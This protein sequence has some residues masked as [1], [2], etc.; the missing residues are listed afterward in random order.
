VVKSFTANAVSRQS[1]LQETRR[2]SSSLAVTWHCA[3]GKY[4][5]I[6]L[7][8]LHEQVQGVPSSV[9]LF[10]VDLDLTIVLAGFPVGIQPQRYYKQTGKSRSIINT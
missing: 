4:V 8:G 10:V 5:R 7:G 2:P 6:P 9:G 1:Y 3:T